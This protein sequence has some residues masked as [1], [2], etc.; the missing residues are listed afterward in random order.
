MA[1]LLKHLALKKKTSLS[2]W[3]SQWFVIILLLCFHP[4]TKVLSRSRKRNFVL[5]PLLYWKNTYRILF[6]KESL[7]VEDSHAVCLILLYC[8]IILLYVLDLLHHIA[9][10]ENLHHTTC[11][12]ANKAFD[13]SL[14]RGRCSHLIKFILC[15][16]MFSSY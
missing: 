11:G 14:K 1:D 16:K 6:F 12:I 9:S 4:N 5:K 15:W 8:S 13:S 7:S 3:L 2:L 10:F